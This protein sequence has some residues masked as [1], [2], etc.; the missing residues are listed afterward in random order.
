MSPAP[1]SH[2]K[3][4]RK[5]PPF[6]SRHY[7][8]YCLRCAAPPACESGNPPAAP[9]KLLQAPLQM[10]PLSLRHG[11]P[12]SLLR[13]NSPWLLLPSLPQLS[14]PAPVQC[15]L[16]VPSPRHPLRFRQEPASARRY[17]PGRVPPLRCFPKEPP[18][19][20]L[21]LPASVSQAAL[22]ETALLPS[23]QTYFLHNSAEWNDLGRTPCPFLPHSYKAVPARNPILPSPF[24]CEAVPGLQSSPDPIPGIRSTSCTA[25]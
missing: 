24:L 11:S 18:P 12:A 20:P 10:P 13:T 6:P 21:S 3:G 2:R 14:A 25:E 7:S 23:L 16:P 8:E 1:A 22:Q 5:Y 19:A 9:V 17:P 4:G 15:A